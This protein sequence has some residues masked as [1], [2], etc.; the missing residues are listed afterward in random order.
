MSAGDIPALPSTRWMSKGA[1]SNALW[2]HAESVVLRFYGGKDLTLETLARVPDIEFCRK[3]LCGPVDLSFSEA[4]D[5][6]AGSLKIEPLVNGGVRLAG[7]SFWVELHEPRGP[8]RFKPGLK[9]AQVAPVLAL[10]W[11]AL[12]GIVEHSRAS[13]ALILRLPAFLKRLKEASPRP[14]P[15][16]L[17]IDPESL[18]E[19]LP[20]AS[21]WEWVYIGEVPLPAEI[22]KHSRPF[23]GQRSA[24]EKKQQELE[25]LSEQFHP[26]AIAARAGVDAAELPEA[27]RSPTVMARG[28][29]WERIWVKTQGAQA[30]PLPLLLQEAASARLPRDRFPIL[31]TD[32]VPLWGS[33]RVETRGDSDEDR[34]FLAWLGRVLSLKVCPVWLGEER[35]PSQGVP[36]SGI[37]YENQVSLRARVEPLDRIEAP[38]FLTV[39]LRDETGK[40]TNPWQYDRFQR[41]KWAPETHQLTIV[42][43]AAFAA[44]FRKTQSWNDSGHAFGAEA[45]GTFLREFKKALQR[46]EIEIPV[47]LNA[48]I[49]Q[50]GQGRVE[51]W[52]EEDGAFSVCHALPEVGVRVWNFPDEMQTW[53]KALQSGLGS[54][55]GTGELPISTTGNKRT[56]G[57]KALRHQGLAAFCLDELLSKALTC[58]PHGA[59]APGSEKPVEPQFT[60]KV[61]KL[62]EPTGSPESSK[63]SLSDLCG[64]RIQAFIAKE[65]PARVEAALQVP[66]AVA[67]ESQF[68]EISQPALPM[69]KVILNR[70]QAMLAHRGPE[71][72]LRGRLGWVESGDFRPVSIEHQPHLGQGPPLEAQKYSMGQPGLDSWLPLLEAGSERDSEPAIRLYWKGQPVESLDA[73]QLRIALDV[74]STG[75]PDTPLTWDWF[76]L[77][78]EVFLQGEAVS[79]HEVLDALSTGLLSHRGKLYR[80]PPGSVPSLKRLERFWASLGG[81]KDGVAMDSQRRTYHPLPR[82]EVLEML[83]LRRRGVEV[84]GDAAWQ[85]LINAFDRLDDPQPRF[86]SIPGFRGELKPYQKSG[87]EWLGDLASLGLGGVLADDMGLGKTV[88]VL[89]HLERLRAENPKLRA[90]VI[91]PSSLVYNWKSEAERFVPELAVRAFSPSESLEAPGLLIITYGLLIEHAEKFL[92]TPWDLAIFDEAQNLKNLSAQRTNVARKLPARIKLALTG[93]PIENHVGEFFSIVDLTVPGALG[94]WE[95]FQRKYPKKEAPSA[96]DLAWLRAKARPLVLR[97]E[98]RQVLSQLPPKIETEHTIEF[99]VEQRK[100]YR[101]TALS[102]NHR[103]CQS[104]DEL[105]ETRSQ[106]AM[107]TA[108]LRLRQICSDPASLPGAVYKGVPPKIIA[109]CERVAERVTQGESCIIFTQFIATLNR[110]Q[111]ELAQLGVPVATISGSTS[112]PERERILREFQESSDARALVMTLKTGGVGLNLT[113]ASH[114]FHLDPWWNPAVEDQATDRAH[115]MGQ[116]R[117]VHVVRYLMRESIEERIKG[118]Q[119]SKR[120]QFE[121]LMGA[122][123][124]DDLA[125]AAGLRRSGSYRLSRAEFEFLTG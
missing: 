74:K 83:A 118:L 29:L 54:L 47:S 81:Q 41:W 50:Q 94:T 48:R 87:V 5:I 112:R 122:E 76:E 20:Q 89:A 53:L 30:R 125:P 4:I 110:T 57:L 1:S 36:V 15:W 6:I 105:G 101:D 62:L 9:D 7:P 78:P 11:T 14:W 109:L 115:R 61:L 16:R 100:L 43:D 67:D 70:I 46:Q 123:T 77:H 37:L 93:T 18:G 97:R 99:D 95:V 60:S 34:V 92:G 22:R 28:S 102:W 75:N 40:K 51:V 49:T 58:L 8:L 66:L 120:A 23:D 33:F 68:L 96:E 19:S 26:L 38:T 82:S 103:V 86:E 35:A 25:P 88:Q 98:K 69:P 31:K 21:P 124:P 3:Y 113:R 71:A 13:E 117:V 65:L 64:Q 45:T 116:E 12:G 106:I 73:S 24:L 121:G 84:V 10:I 104:I 63:K 27:L 44:A 111:A 107:L 39:Q 90:I 56:L 114:V 72:M 59:F 79:P 85:R 80:I 108:L 42:P 32:S 55:P 52:L 2:P 91:V 17:A 119:Q